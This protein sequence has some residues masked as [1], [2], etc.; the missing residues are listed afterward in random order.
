VRCGEGK[1]VDLLAAQ[2]EL[3]ARYALT[4]EIERLTGERTEAGAALAAG[5]I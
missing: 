4:A 2:V 1:V 3:S 5:R